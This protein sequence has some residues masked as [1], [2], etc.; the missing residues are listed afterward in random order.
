MS[1]EPDVE[2][3][4]RKLKSFREGEQGVLDVI[5]RGAK[6]LPALRRMLFEREPSGLFQARCRAVAALAALKAHDVLIDFLQTDRGI[7]DPVERLGEDAVI[8]AAARALVNVRE[9][10][11][12]EVFLSLARRPALTG[13]IAALG[14]FERTEAIPVLI[15]ALEDDASRATAESALKKLGPPARTALLAAASSGTSA[16]Q[17]ESELR[18]RQRR[19]ELGVLARMGVPRKAWPSVR[20]LVYD[21]DARLAALACQIGLNYAPVAQRAQCV[22]RLIELLTQDDWMLCEDIERWLVDHFDSARQEI[23]RYLEGSP[24]ATHPAATSWIETILR[25]VIARAQA[26][27]PGLP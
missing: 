22:R 24:S 4:I 12:F 2:Q 25:R 11:A 9:R 23:D 8:N 20:P 21:P 6:A 14:A 26:A 18:R 16:G 17:Q 27:P 15:D 7:V 3:A 13:V 10:R 5:A 19:G 1:K